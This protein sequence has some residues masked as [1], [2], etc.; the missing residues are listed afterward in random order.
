[1]AFTILTR[2]DL[3]TVEERLD[4]LL[5]IL[6]NSKSSG[7]NN[8]YTTQ[9]L[10]KKLSV[11]TKTIQHWREGKLIQFSQVN[12]K[13]YYTERAVE[14]FLANHSIKRKSH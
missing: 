14:D 10:A 7:G 2:D 11:S 3:Q 1:M 9:Q 4:Q 8:I 6:Q 13:I 12:N 5:Q